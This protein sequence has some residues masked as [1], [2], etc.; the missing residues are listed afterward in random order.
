MFAPNSW[1]DFAASG[2]LETIHGIKREATGSGCTSVVEVTHAQGCVPRIR[3]WGRDEVS[4]SC[5][6][7]PFLR[8]RWG[9]MW[10]LVFNACHETQAGLPIF[11]IRKPPLT[12]CCAFW[13]IFEWFGFLAKCLELQTL[14]DDRP[15]WVLC[16]TENSRSSWSSADD[17]RWTDMRKH[18]GSN[19]HGGQWKS[20]DFCHEDHLQE[21]LWEMF[22]TFSTH[23]I[24]MTVVFSPWHLWRQT[25]L[26]DSRSKIWQLAE[27]T[28]QPTVKYVKYVKGVEP[29]CEMH[30]GWVNPQ[31]WI[32]DGSF[33]STFAIIFN[34]SPPECPTH[35]GYR[36]STWDVATISN[37]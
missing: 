4:T 16:R 17:L 14:P 37:D 5:A 10:N 22:H 35:I 8:F 13:I 18:A 28:G 21:T 6:L 1:K 33:N 7:H 27:P 20:F 26:A 15:P 29:G 31:A 11:E 32:W 23:R 12:G 34:W 3:G 19:R 2:Y 30:L 36:W 25:N 9:T 24:S